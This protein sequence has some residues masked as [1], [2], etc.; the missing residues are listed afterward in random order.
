MLSLTKEQYDSIT[1]WGKAG[2]P[3][4]A[5][6]LLGGRVIAGERRVEQVFFLANNDHSPEHFS[7]EPAEQFAVIRELRQKGW[8]LLGNFHSHPSTPARPSGEDKRLA[9]DGRLSYVILSLA[10]E[11]P[12]LKSFRIQQGKSVEEKIEIRGEEAK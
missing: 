12:G 9:F 10:E 7:M 11:Q 2:L 8:M 6:G 1:A 4:E 5:C 3:N